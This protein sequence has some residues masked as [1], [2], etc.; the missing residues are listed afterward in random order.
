MTATLQFIGPADAPLALSDLSKWVA[1][2]GAQGVVTTYLAPEDFI[3]AGGPD[4]VLLA[5]IADHPEGVVMLGW[6]I[7]PSEV[8]EVALVEVRFRM[9]AANQGFLE[10]A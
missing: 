4:S 2:P 1:G 9:V 3:P 5:R 7:I 10:A 6:T 8:E